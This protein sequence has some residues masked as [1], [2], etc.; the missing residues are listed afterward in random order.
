MTKKDPPSPLDM[1]SELL[2]T[3]LGR[4]KAEGANV[5]ASVDK[6]S[7]DMTALIRTIE[8]K[9][10]DPA[11]RA[12]A[13]AEV[14]KMIDLITSFGR[15]LGSAIAHK[16]APMGQAVRDANSQQVADGMRKLLEFLKNPS[17]EN[18]AATKADMADLKKTLEAD[19]AAAPPTD[20]DDK[21]VN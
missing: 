10:K 14:Q 1:I 3:A 15:A 7:A 19:V 6:A 11:V 20:S 8:E 5:D 16:D 21:K 13:T 9:A 17:A 4:I 18:A 12:Q 2:V